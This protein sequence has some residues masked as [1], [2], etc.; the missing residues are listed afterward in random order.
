MVSASWDCCMVQPNSSAPLNHPSCVGSH[1]FLSA[2]ICGTSR[3]YLSLH[4][5]L[6]TTSSDRAGALS[7]NMVHS[8]AGHSSL[9]FLSPQ[10]YIVGLRSLAYTLENGSY[11]NSRDRR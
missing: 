7:C 11:A 5:I 6:T 2:C 10:P 4:P 3:S 1:R 8:G 9:F